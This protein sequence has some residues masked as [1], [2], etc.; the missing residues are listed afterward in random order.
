MA[1][2]TISITLT[3]LIFILWSG[4]GDN[5][6][7]TQELYSRYR[8]AIPAK[9]RLAA[10]APEASHP[11]GDVGNQAIYPQFAFS[12]VS[13]INNVILNLIDNLEAFVDLPPTMYNR[14]TQEFVWGPFDNESTPQKG[15]Q[16]F[17]YV[18][19]QG[20]DADYQYTYA[21]LRGMVGEDPA[22]FRPVI[23]GSTTL[24]NADESFGSG[25]VLWDFEAD[26]E[27]EEVLN[28]GHDGQYPRG[29]FAAV[30]EHWTSQEDESVEVTA[31][32]AAF[33][34]F[35]F[36]DSE[37]GAAPINLDYLWGRV[38]TFEHHMDYLDFHYV[39]DLEGTSNTGPED[40]GIRMAFDSSGI[41]RAEVNV[42][43]GD[44]PN[45]Y[46]DYH[47][48]G[49][50]CWDT[51]LQRVYLLLE[52]TPDDEGSSNPTYPFVAEGTSDNCEIEDLQQVPSLEDIDQDLLA[53]LG[54][55]ASHGIP[56][57]IEANGGDP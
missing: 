39:A 46:P 55:V 8:K 7:D 18:R 13:T 21:F 3:A 24:D 56:A 11:E 30:Y 41:G 23:M 47:L 17:V 22:S 52:L 36:D 6:N 43:G 42:V 40:M 48:E 5:P 20:D 14:K 44:L 15:D 57:L 38:E 12:V 51:A 35:I 26:Y 54:F 25:I 49:V 27:L 28:P 29:R 34:D 16:I 9:S 32:V 33:R 31:V 53:T 1:R 2:Y 10:K 4:C 50:E 45:D 37:I 19:D